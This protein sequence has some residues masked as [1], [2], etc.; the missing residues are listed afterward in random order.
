MCTL[1][2]PIGTI[3]V[4]LS[5]FLFSRLAEAKYGGGSGTAEDPYQIATAEDLIALGETPEDYD[6]HFVLTDDID[7]AGYVFD[8]AVIAGL[9][10]VVGVGRVGTPFT[11]IFDGNGHTISHLM[12]TGGRYLGL[13]GRLGSGDVYGCAVKDLGILDVNIMGSEYVGGLVG[14]NF[15]TVT[16]CYSSGAVRGTVQSV[17]GLVGQNELQGL[18]TECYSTGV[19]EGSSEVGGLVGTNWGGYVS[20]CY[21]M[22]AVSKGFGI[23]GLV[24]CNFGT[25][26]DC[27]STGAVNG[28]SNAGGLVGGGSGTVTDCYSTGA[29]SGTESVGGLAGS[30]SAS[31]SNCYSAGAVSGYEYVGGLVGANSGFVS[32]SYS[33][34]PVNGSD[35]SGSWNIGGLVGRN[36]GDVS[37]CS[38][39][40][41]VWGKD[42]VGGLVGLNKLE[43]TVTQ[44]YSMGAVRGDDHVGG[45]AGANGGCINQCYSTGMSTGSGQYIGGL[46]GENWE[47]SLTYCYSTGA[48]NGTE[49]VGGLV[50]WSTSMEGGRK[51]F[52]DILTSGRATS[53]GGTG[54]TTA[55]MQTASTFL[56][57]GWDFVG[58]TAN[59]SADIWTICEGK[60]YP[61]L[62]W[63]FVPGEFNDDYKIDFNDVAILSIHWRKA[64]SN[65]LWCRGPDL[66]NDGFVDFEDL[67]VLAENWLMDISDR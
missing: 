6:K 32:E 42:C 24:G 10:F 53:D 11:G 4:L 23:G 26:N 35:V 50:G 46:V 58:E 9:T 49:Y 48:V 57:A 27:Y 37:R 2:K 39:F 13:F 45:L 7:L 28:S 8:K 62:T 54:K 3:L 19:V 40:G 47:G 25:V 15:G 36:Y 60:D 64:A 20:Q 52:W 33:T 67:M 65:F 66:T 34:G 29:V 18:V 51:C 16:Q 12:I 63:Q 44:C 38:S 56:A 43:G 61:K 30:N 5:I 14:R 21:S 1:S 59:G 31:V 17:G 41:A 55:G 22:C